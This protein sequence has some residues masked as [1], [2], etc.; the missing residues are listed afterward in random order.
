MRNALITAVLVLLIPVSGCACK[1]TDDVADSIE[2]LRD[3]THSI[4]KNYKA[5]LDRSAAPAL[6][7]GPEGETPEQLKKRKSAH[8]ARW[9]KHITHQK[10]LMSANNPLADRTNTWARVCTDREKPKESN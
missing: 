3:N 2:V 6:P 9:A 1:V 8:E 5:L 4:S 7:P 10:A